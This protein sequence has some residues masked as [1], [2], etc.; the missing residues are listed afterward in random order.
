MS[1]LLD[2]AVDIVRALPADER[3]EIARVML[4]LADTDREAEPLDPAHL[5]AVL[6][7]LAQAERGEFATPEQVE[8]TFR[9]FDV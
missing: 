5:A 4:A 2:R 1:E 7:G 9:R 8:A 6:D 3:N